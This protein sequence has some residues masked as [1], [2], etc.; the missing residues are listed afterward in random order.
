[1]RVSCNVSL[2]IR[3]CVSVAPVCLSESQPQTGYT[4]VTRGPSPTYIRVKVARGLRVQS[5]QYQRD[6]GLRR[7]C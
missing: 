5:T 4:K 2:D 7:K 1:M 6:P 3:L